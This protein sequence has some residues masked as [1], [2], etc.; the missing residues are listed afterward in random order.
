MNAFNEK[1]T[2]PLCFTKFMVWNKYCIYSYT[3]VF[4]LLT[5]RF[6]IQKSEHCH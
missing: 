5:Y 6:R 3:V 4:L 2:K 1:I